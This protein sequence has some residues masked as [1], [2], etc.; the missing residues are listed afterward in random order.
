MRTARSVVVP[1]TALLMVFAGCSTAPKSDTARANLKD[2]ADVTLRKFD[3]RDPSLRQTID[4]AAG[5][6]VFPSVGKGGLGVGGAY[7][8]G[9]V[10]ENGQ[11]TGFCDLSQASIGFQAGGQ[12]YAE[13][14]VFKDRDAL[15]KFKQGTYALSADASAVA[16][17]PGAS[18]QA[19]FKHG[20][21]VFTATNA[22]LMYEAAVAGQKFRTSSVEP[23]R[24]N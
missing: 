6:A 19:E 24:A 20:V 3:R 23:A 22:G 15:N 2:E 4:R 8:R 10:Y 21:A 17:K 16:I 11:M 9:V 5:Y 12:D 7:G 13:V 14:L 18:A 1:L